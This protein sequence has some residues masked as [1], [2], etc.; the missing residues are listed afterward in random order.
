MGIDPGSRHCGFGLVLW[1]G[2]TFEMLEAGVISPATNED[3]A[4]RLWRLGDALE[5]LFDLHRPDHVAVESV[6]LGKNA[7]SAFKLG[8]ARGVCMFLAQGSGARVFEYP[9]KTIKKC[10]TGS[11][12]ADKS[13]VQAMVC[14]RLRIGATLLADASDALAVALAHA[15]R[16]EV[17]Q[18]LRAGGREAQR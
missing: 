12:S 16:F 17:E 14:Q 2:D 11:G 5:R 18:R 9:A 6:F 15:E 7:D 10:V 1:R 4:S 8:H 13:L 3:F